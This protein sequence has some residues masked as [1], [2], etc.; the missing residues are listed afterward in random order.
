MGDKT[1]IEWTD[2]TWNPIRGCSRVSEGCRHCYAEQVAA[3]FS[4]PGQP[5]EDLAEFVTR[6]DG[7]REA[8]WTGR[9]RFAPDMDQ[10]LRWRRPRRIFANSMSD[11]FHEE[12][13]R[14]E[15][16]GVYSIAVAGHQLHGHIIQILTKRA[17]RMREMLRDQAFWDQV[18]N[19]AGQYVMDGTDPLNRRSDDARATMRDYGPEDPPPG[20][21]LGVSAENQETAN[22]RIPHLLCTPAAV[23]FCSAE[24]L[25]GPID[26]RAICYMDEDAEMRIDSLAG[27]AWVDNSLSGSAYD[28]C[29]KLDWIIVGGESGL[30]ARPMHPSWARSIREQCAEASTAFFFKQWGE[31][32]PST[33]ETSVD[34]NAGWFPL[35]GQL[36][37]IAKKHELYPES[38]AAYV[39]RLG[40]KRAGRLLDGIEHN[41]F[42]EASCAPI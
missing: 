18:N 38:G 32:G 36:G 42:P 34:P 3:R 31:W 24:P 30:A 23:R 40:K 33:P 27:D 5:Y 35:R 21:W 17:A 1:A 7:S 25:L 12:M 39:E 28:T 19:E 20:V 37:G 6:P 15:V 8:R 4:G 13:T 14:E 16:A 22:E 10:P 9:L 41:A 11:L 29:E 26:F 2:A